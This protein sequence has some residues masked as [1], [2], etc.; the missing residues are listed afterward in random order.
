M[1]G[2]VLRRALDRVFLGVLIAGAAAAI[3]SEWKP[4]ERPNPDQI[5]SE[6][7]ADTRAGRYSEA[8][9]KH[10]WFHEH[11]LEYSP[12]LYGVRL[13]FALS[14]WKRL[15]EAYPPALRKLEAVRDEA[16]ERVRG[17]QD[18]R[19]SFHDFAAINQ[20]LGQDGK[21]A[22]LFLWQ[23]SHDS[24]A[25]STIF[26]IA[27]PSLVARKDYRTCGRYLDPD[28]SLD[29]MRRLFEE[30]SKLA[31]QSD[32]AK[33][34]RAIAEK[35]FSHDATT[36]VALLVLNDRRVDAERIAAE[37]RKTLDTKES[38]E[39][40]TRALRGELPPAWP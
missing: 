15:G 1:I 14:S 9:A 27:Q 2:S 7:E 38:R 29:R 40:I 4:G 10:V 11:A 3:A 6:A 30:T 31:A 36:L 24:K 8:L 20:V 35:N 12:G 17:A 28:H 25:A 34:T 16:A 13:S 39:S 21:T 19:H 18:L 33:E 26:E 22:D 5:L 23:D 32:Y 37:A